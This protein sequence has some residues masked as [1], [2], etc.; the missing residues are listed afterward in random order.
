M[1]IQRINPGRRSSSAVIGVNIVYLA[2]Q[3]GVP[4]DSVSSQTATILASID[5]LLAEAGT[6]K[7]R[8]LQA[9]IW[10]ADMN[11]FDAMNAVWEEWVAPG[12]SPARATGESRLAAPGYT[13]SKLSLSLRFRRDIRECRAAET[14]ACVDLQLTI[15]AVARQVVPVAQCAECGSERR[16]GSDRQRALTGV[17]ISIGHKNTIDERSGACHR[18]H[19]TVPH[20][21][22][23]GRGSHLGCFPVIRCSES[24]VAASFVRRMPRRSRNCSLRHRPTGASRVAVTGGSGER[25]GLRLRNEIEGVVIRNAVA[26]VIGQAA[27]PYEFGQ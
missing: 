18:N 16:V 8:L 23:I 9:T 17:E 10:L 4:G 3:V 7:S 20:D 12:H 26:L 11:D 1:T 19:M 22:P 14:Y 13:R 27:R 21:D 2:G 15:V 6:D 24:V 25:E 5:R